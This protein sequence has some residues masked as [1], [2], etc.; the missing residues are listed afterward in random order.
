M[1]F[2][3]VAPASPEEAVRLLGS[4]PAGAVAVLAGG[5]D[6]LLDLDDGRLAPTTVVSLRRLPWNTWRWE[7]GALVVG[8]TA[9]LADLEADPELARRHP[10][11]YEGIRAV[12]SP[13]LRHR[14]TLGGNLGRASPASDLIPILLALGARAQ[15]VGPSGPRDVPVARL[16]VGPRATSLAAG[17]LIASV[18]VPEA[19]PS[20]YLWQRVRPAHD[21][22]QVGVAAA[23]SPAGRRWHVALGGTWPVPVE[24]G[25]AEAIGAERRPPDDRTRAAAERAASEARF[26]TD[27]RATE[28]YRRLVLA[29]L[30]RRAVQRVAA[31]G[32]GP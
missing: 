13:A 17:E 30:Y 18:T 2:S 1:G 26:Q 5:T 32:D 15:V 11:L 22:S 6:L 21:I 4:G 27:K 9:P 24:S 10:G 23:W 7:S 31:L 29:V 25:S 14:A 12:G 3:L 8:S 16:I 20:T 19:R 28:E